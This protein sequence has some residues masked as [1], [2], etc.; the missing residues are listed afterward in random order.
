MEITPMMMLP[1]LICSVLMTTIEVI[2]LLITYF[3]PDWATHLTRPPNFR[4]S[5]T[6]PNTTPNHYNTKITVKSI[7]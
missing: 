4:I 3:T 6:T 5:A 2:Y 7:K 1:V